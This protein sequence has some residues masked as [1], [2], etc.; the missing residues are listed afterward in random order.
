MCS[1]LQSTPGLFEVLRG[2]VVAVAC[3]FRNRHDISK[4]L[5]S[6]LSLTR[7]PKQANDAVGYVGVT[8]VIIMFSGP[9]AVIKTVI[10]TR[11]TASLP[12]MFTAASFLN[13]ALCEP[14]S[15]LPTRKAAF[16]RSDLLCFC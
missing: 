1:S 13:C 6:P 3:A 7:C 8:M 16:E 4:G 2:Q 11:S 15:P 12:P 10:N 5:S 9:L 14:K